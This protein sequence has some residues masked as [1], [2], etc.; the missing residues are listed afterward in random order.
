V[1]AAKDA[2]GLHV[3]LGE[4][5]ADAV[6][7]AGEIIDKFN[8]W[9]RGMLFTTA[10][11]W[12]V[13]RAWHELRGNTDEAT[14]AYEKHKIAR[15]KALDLIANPESG[16]QFAEEVRKA[17]DEAEARVEG[18]VQRQAD[19]RDK[20]ASGGGT[21]STEAADAQQAAFDEALAFL[22]T[23]E[24]A[25]LESYERRREAILEQTGITEIA[26]QELLNELRE[27]Y[28]EDQAEL[29]LAQQES[30]YDQFVAS[31]DQKAEYISQ[32]LDEVNKATDGAYKKQIKLFEGYVKKED[33]GWSDHAN[34]ALNAIGSIT[35]G[36]AKESGALFEIGKAAAVAHAIINTAQGVTAALAMGPWGIPLAA[37]IAAAGAAQIATI[38]ST[39]PSSGSS[40]GISAPS[41][42]VSAPGTPIAEEIPDVEPERS[43]QDVNIVVEPG[44]YDSNSVRDLIVAINEELSDGI[45]LNVRVG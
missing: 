38:V 8:V 41:G 3:V 10:A 26:R 14:A 21:Q 28:N 19:M 20:L 23:E 17:I 33:K 31:Y 7:W 15:D 32:Y 27:Q 2:G 44:I 16:K 45:D 39:S 9:R 1:D 42:G 12:D 30:E 43:V 36:F 29:R 5:F 13:V 35:E 40:S 18:I 11:I 25:L 24:D 37:V 34:F 22:Q 4:M 6:E